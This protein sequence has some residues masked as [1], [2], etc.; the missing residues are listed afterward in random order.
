[1]YKLG[2]GALSLV[3]EWCLMVQYGWAAFRL[4]P[5]WV[6][7]ISAIYFLFSALMIALNEKRDFNK[8][9]CPMLEGMVLLNLCLMSGV[10][11]ASAANSFYLPELPMWLVIFICVILPLAVLA[12]WI[13]F[14]KKGRWRVM[15][16]F[17]WVALPICYVATMIFTAEI[18]PDLELLYPFEAL[19]YLEFGLFEMFGW[20]L[21]AAL[22]ELVIGYGFFLL[23]F[24]A[25]GKLAKKIVLPHLRTV[26]VNEDGTTTMIPSDKEEP[27]DA[28][29]TEKSS[30]IATEKAKPQAT[31]DTPKSQSVAKSKITKEP[32]GPK[33]QPRQKE[34]KP[35]Q[36]KSKTKAKKS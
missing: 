10:A 16:P 3:L 18:N 1:M 32:K 34:T 21:V 31:K 29:K 27:Q 30:K 33:L 4:F 12:D 2:L 15:A 11:I 20:F 25:S 35:E 6:L 24:A 8:N 22:L 5:T 23:D 9:Y 7:L 28:A 26:V 36:V 13:V 19:N 17:Y 14:V